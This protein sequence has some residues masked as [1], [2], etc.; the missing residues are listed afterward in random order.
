MIGLSIESSTR[1]CAVGL[2]GEHGVIDEESALDEGF[3][4]A[5]KLHVFTERLL[6]RNKLKPTDLAFVAVNKGP[7]SYTGLRIGVSM[8]KGLCYSLDIPLVSCDSLTILCH[9]VL[10]NTK[11]D[12]YIPMIDARRMEVYMAR[13]DAQGNQ[14]SEIEARII[15]EEFLEDLKGKNAIVFGDGASKLAEFESSGNVTILTDVHPTCE[16]MCR[17][18][19]QRF[20][21][22]KFE[23]IAYFEPFYLKDFIAGKR[24]NLLEESRK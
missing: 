8:A 6:E 4:H 12:L 7:G 19:W 20:Q 9:S 24:K 16:A 2:I 22:E 21:A 1:Y 23:D 15:D 18:A 14:L 3:S 13:F 5:E 17:P 10:N 11:A